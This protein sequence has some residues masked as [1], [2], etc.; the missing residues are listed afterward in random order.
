[1]KRKQH[2]AIVAGL[3]ILALALAACASQPE[4]ESLPPAE[5]APPEESPVEE[6]VEEPA[7]GGPIFQISTE[8]SEARFIIEEVLNGAD[9]TVVGTAANSVTGEIVADYADTSSAQVSLLSVDLS[10]LA[11]DN[12]FRNRA[13]HEFILLTG[14]E[15]NQ[16]ATFSS[17]AISGLPG[18]ANVGESY[19]VQITGDL[20]MHGVTQAVTFDGTVTPV[21]ETRLEGS[22]STTITYG[23]FGVA[24]LRLPDQVASVEDT[25]VLEID[26]VAVAQ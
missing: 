14:D 21:S 1:M 10:A 23:D 12:D 26:V 11:T 22:A 9:K 7:S 6:P 15:A 2:L 4:S 8:E 13:I 19:P 24:I 20:T 16:F 5:E 17:T 18:S 3:V 25:A